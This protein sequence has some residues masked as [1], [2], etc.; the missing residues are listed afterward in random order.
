MPVR[1]VAALVVLALGVSV[2]LPVPQ[3]LKTYFENGQSFYAIGEYEYAIKEYAKIVKFRH[4]AV[5]VDQVTIEISETLTLP[6]QEAA[7]YQLG[8]SY[9]KSGDYDEAI[10]AYRKVLEGKVPERFRAT[11]QYQIA[12]TRFAQ[13]Q[14]GQAAEEYGNFV[15]TFPSSDLVD[16]AYFYQGW[17]LFKHQEYEEAIAVLRDMLAK[18]PESKYAPDAQF[19][20]AS[21]YFEQ[22]EY[23]GTVK[24]ASLVLERHPE[25]ASI[26]NAEYLQAN[27]Y[28]KLGR[29]DDAIAAYQEIIDLYDKMFEILRS[30]FREGRNLDFEE[31]K[32]LFESSFLKIADIYREQ[33]GDYAKAY[34]TYVIAQETVREYDY[35]AKLQKLIGDN[36]LAWEAYDKAV[37]AYTQVMT[38][39]PE[40]PY[41]PQA[42]FQVGESYYYAGDH[43]RARAE[44]LA[45]LEKFPDTDTELRAQALYSAGWSSR[46]IDKLDEAL[47]TYHRVLRDYSR[48]YHAPICMLEVGRAAYDKGQYEEALEWYRK[49]VRDYPEAEQLNEAS[50]FMGLVLKK[51]GKNR[52]AIEAFDK[53]GEEA[54]PYYV[55]SQTS[56]AN[57]YAYEKKGEEAEQVLMGLLE[58][59]V[60]DEKLEPQTHYQIAQVYLTQERYPKAVEHY[61]IVIERFAESQYVRDSYYGRGS[62]SHKLLRFDDAI[63]DYNTLLDMELEPKLKTRTKLALAL[64]YSAVDRDEEARGFLQ[65]VSEGAYPNLARAARVQLVSLAEKG[66]PRKAVE[67]YKDLLSGAT[68]DQERA[69]VLTRLANV[70]YKLGRYQEAI[71]AARN[72]VQVSDNPEGIASGYAI[73]GNSYMKMKRYE[74]AVREFRQTVDKFPRSL[75]APTALFQIG[76]AYHRLNAEASGAERKA[77]LLSRS[78]GAFEEFYTK[79]PDAR[80]ASLA[81]YY[82]SWGAYQK[83]DWQKA[84]DTF[85]T[86]VDHF[87]KSSYAPEA[88][89]RAGE[90]IFNLKEY[91]KAYD[92]YQRVI[93]RY[94]KS[95]WVDDAIYNKAWCFVHQGRKAEAVPLFEE[96]IEKYRDGYY[97]PRSQFTLGDYYYNAE[98]YEKATEEYEKFIAMFPDH[99]RVRRAQVLLEN[100]GEIAAYNMYSEGERLFDEE[101]FKE[102]IAVFLTVREQYPKSSS[103]VN[104]L[105]NIGAAYQAMEDFDKA[106][107]QYRTLVE[108]YSDEAKFLDQVKF[109]E[110]QLKELIEARVISMK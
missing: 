77:A 87:P 30:S 59:V 75:V 21:C 102:A 88:Q 44:Y 29:Y 95:E 79:Y 85:Q 43:E 99:K 64:V 6:I 86:L 58:S 36:Y 51:Q 65:E 81:Y 22:G 103:A 28:E 97:G 82:A 23:E 18:Y 83:G 62:A 72:L 32:R 46:Q 15:A 41:P 48:S 110:D 84:S 55:A 69:V 1:L 93:D 35:K 40:S 89:F 13:E 71:D 20:I 26:A 27:S 38:N 98:E 52:E 57:L 61:S 74:D 68:D 4:R 49:L 109:A 100:L 60:G 10:E 54:G 80:E 76:F 24:E 8:N 94:S 7:W 96:I 42:Q 63:S 73:A 106:A 34:D 47:E 101:K 91:A 67:I 107:E 37:T 12:D 17:S 5:D 11:V 3:N 53:V 50:Y 105:V 104:S 2:F 90:A 108:Q 39:Y 14:F 56:V 25:S 33:K 31:Y 9:K 78:I 19:R 70:Y 45:L 66:D 16:K 92:L